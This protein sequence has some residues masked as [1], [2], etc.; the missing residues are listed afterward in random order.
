MEAR[1]LSLEPFVKEQ[2]RL[3]QRVVPENIRIHMDGDAG[4]ATINA[5][6]TRIQQVI[7][8]LVLNARDAMPDGGDVRVALKRAWVRE[9]DTPLPGMKSGEWVQITVADT[10]TG[11]AP[12]T[13]PNIFEPFFTTKAPGEGTG[14]GL[15]QV[16]GIVKRHEGYIDVDTKPG[17]GTTFTIYF[18]FLVAKP[19]E[20]QTPDIQGAA[21]GNGETILVVEDNADARKAL[22]ESLALLNYHTLQ[23]SNGKE[24]LATW[25]Q[26]RDEVDLILSDAVMPEMGGIALFHALK[27]EA[28]EVKVVLI[29]GHLLDTQPENQ[30]ETLMRQGLTG[31]L[32]KPVD[33]EAL[34]A[35]LAES[36]SR[37]IGSSHQ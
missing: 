4:E 19:V 33:L 1:P 31:W 36:F 18:P 16:Y 28:P 2:V 29:T 10:G 21:R 24:A 11:I 8:N 7:M 30:F 35:M 22:V 14:L 12:E 27:Q 34:A 15:A 17:E 20:P 6:P 23:A 37:S 13:L 32:R 5:D 25:V 3:L 9:K 26:H